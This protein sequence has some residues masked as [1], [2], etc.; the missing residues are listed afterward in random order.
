MINI[1]IPCLSQFRSV[2][3]GDYKE[4]GFPGFPEMYGSYPLSKIAVTAL[5]RV[6]Q[7]MFDTQRPADDIIVNAVRRFFSSSTDVL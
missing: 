3:N 5:S 2:K 7:R 4:K 1:F 6:Q